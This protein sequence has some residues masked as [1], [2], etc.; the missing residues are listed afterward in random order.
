[1]AHYRVHDSSLTSSAADFAASH[2][3][4]LS[5]PSVAAGE[6][7]EYRNEIAAY[8][9][10]YVAHLALSAAARGN[11]Q[12]ALQ[13]VS[14]MEANGV[15]VA[16]LRAQVRVVSF[17]PVRLVTSARRSVSRFRSASTNR[18]RGCGKISSRAADRSGNSFFRR[19][20]RFS[21]SN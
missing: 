11:V 2:F 6:L 3:R 1:V 7:L 15:P 9:R 19:R 4:V 18:N 21:A 8:I 14:V 5:N 12:A 13:T 16:L 17:P 20:R 10:N